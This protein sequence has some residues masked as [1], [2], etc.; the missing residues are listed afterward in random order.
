MGSRRLVIC[1][2]FTLADSWRDV[3]KLW[4]TVDALLRLN[5]LILCLRRRR[6]THLGSQL[7]SISDCQL[8]VGEHVTDV[9]VSQQSQR[10]RL[11]EKLLLC[12]V[13]SICSAKVDAWV[14]RCKA[15]KVEL[16]CAAYLLCSIYQCIKH[17]AVHAL[18]LCAS[19]C[20]IGKGLRNI[21][22]H[23]LMLFAAQFPVH[24]SNR[25]N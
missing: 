6:M 1:C 13:E 8:T 9:A 17:S 7:L 25:M 15:M 11:S 22:H 3:S 5:P 12:A 2:S 18:V 24:I 23:R 21:M 19:E 4:G 16:G 14:D 10:A 20:C